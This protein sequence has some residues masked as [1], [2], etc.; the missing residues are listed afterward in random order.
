MKVY[1]SNAQI[2]HWPSVKH[3][4]LIPVSI[5]N[6]LINFQPIYEIKVKLKKTNTNI[7][8][9]IDSSSVL[10][11]T[12]LVYC[13]VCKQASSFIYLFYKYCREKSKEQ[14][15]TLIFGVMYVIQSPK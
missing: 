6:D 10:K 15:L 7:R 13:I 8:I 14:Y 4:L 3:H 12:F 9:H 2:P 11:D 5:N 1:E